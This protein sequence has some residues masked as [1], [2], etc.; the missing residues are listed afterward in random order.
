MFTFSSIVSPSDFVLFQLRPLS[1]L[2]GALNSIVFEGYSETPF[3][4]LTVLFVTFMFMELAVFVPVVFSR[5]M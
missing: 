5:V 1:W 2:S 3:L 4:V